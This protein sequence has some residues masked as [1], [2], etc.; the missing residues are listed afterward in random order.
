M[1]GHI[2]HTTEHVENLELR[3]NGLLL[4]LPSF[5]SVFGLFATL[6]WPLGLIVIAFFSKR[7]AAFVLLAACRFASIGRKHTLTRS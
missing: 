6:K 1:L 7:C 4:A 5:N 3:M 2:E